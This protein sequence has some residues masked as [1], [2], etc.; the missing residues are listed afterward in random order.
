MPLGR[1]AAPRVEL[2]DP[3]AL[4][5]LLAGQPQ[6]PL[7]GHLDREPMAV[8]AGLARYVESLHGLEPGEDV[9]EY[10]GLDVMHPGHAVRGRRPLVEG[11]ERAALSGLQR[12]LEELP[13]LPAGQHLMLHGGQVDGRGQVGEVARA[14]C[15]RGAACVRVVRGRHDWWSSCG[16]LPG[17]PSARSRGFAGGTRRA[18]GGPA[19]PPSLAASPP[20]SATLS[21]MSR[22]RFYWARGPQRLTACLARCC[23]SGG[24]GVIWSAGLPPGS[25]HPRVAPGCLPRQL[26]PSTPSR[27]QR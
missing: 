18:G 7:H 26:S 2:R 4:D 8:P 22:G 17:W 20:G 24:S 13:V 12:P 5:R 6:F 14:V 21:F 3:V 11:P 25:H 16:A 19:V 27:V 1:L 15:L 23:S 10:P 9:L